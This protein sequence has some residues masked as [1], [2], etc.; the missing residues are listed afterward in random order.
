MRDWNQAGHLRELI[1]RVNDI[2]RSHPALQ[3]NDT[4]QFYPTDNRALLWY[5]KSSGDDR[6]YVVAN[7]TPAQLQHGFVEMPL[8]EFGLAAD[9]EYVVEDLLDG[10]SYTWRGSRNYVRLDP[11]ERMAHIFVVRR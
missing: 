6:V 11:A 5:G 9:A 2:R 4:L 1:A 8:A 7:T 10:T 3:Q